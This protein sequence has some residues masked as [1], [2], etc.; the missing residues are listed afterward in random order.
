MFLACVRRRKQLGQLRRQNAVGIK[1][2]GEGDDE[3]HGDVHPPQAVT[4]PVVRRP[5][6]RKR[7]PAANEWPSPSHHHHH[8]QRPRRRPA[9]SSPPA[10]RC[11]CAPKGRDGALV[12]LELCAPQI[13]HLPHWLLALWRLAERQPVRRL[14][15][16]AARR[17]DDTCAPPLSGGPKSAAKGEWGKQEKVQRHR[18]VDGFGGA[19]AVPSPSDLEGDPWVQRLALPPRGAPSCACACAHAHAHVHA[20]DL[21]CMYA[22][23]CHVHARVRVHACACACTCSGRAYF[24]HRVKAHPC[25]MRA[26]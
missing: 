22:C 12:P 16:R 14:R 24:S 21:C 7:P 5:V 6:I 8:R 4:V 15:G 25:L 23:A 13:L 2:D 11:I 20:H 1:R 3:H 19:F 9:H 17:D 26:T 10:A 18:V